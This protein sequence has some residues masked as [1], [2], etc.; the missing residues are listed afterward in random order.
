MYLSH[1]VAAVPGPTAPISTLATAASAT[2]PTR[3]AGP[4]RR[5]AS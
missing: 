2:R 4:V 5:K 1:R 3:K